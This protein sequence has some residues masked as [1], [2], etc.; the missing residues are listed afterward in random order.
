MVK[1]VK[2]GGKKRPV[3]MGVWGLS[4]FTEEKGIDLTGFF[5]MLQGGIS[6]KDQ[7]HLFQIA[8]N[9][10]NRKTGKDQEE[11]SIQQIA[12]WCDEEAGKFAEMSNIVFETLPKPKAG[13]EDSENEKE[14][15]N[16]KG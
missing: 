8:L 14:E 9:E 15:G 7:L 11:I 10:G 13:E 3:S 1:Y 12:D 4:E 5:E 2:L 16:A 6:L